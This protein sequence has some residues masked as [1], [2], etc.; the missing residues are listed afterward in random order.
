MGAIR[1][2]WP[3]L[4]YSPYHTIPICDR[5]DYNHPT[6]VGRRVSYWAGLQHTC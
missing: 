5:S 2:N 1:P 6:L 4:A 3:S